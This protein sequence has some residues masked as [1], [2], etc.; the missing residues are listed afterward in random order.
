MRY[1]VVTDDYSDKMGEKVTGSLQAGWELYGT[2]FISQYGYFC[3]AMIFD[4]HKNKD[5]E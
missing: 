5:K 1:K 4:E 3:Q 2:P